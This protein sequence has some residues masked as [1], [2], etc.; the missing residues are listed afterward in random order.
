MTRRPLLIA[1][2]ISEIPFTIVK[3]ALALGH[4]PR[5]NALEPLSSVSKAL[6]LLLML[7]DAVAPMRLTDISRALGLNK[8]TALRLLVTLEKFGFVEKDLQRK[9]YRIGSNAFYVGSGYIAEGNSRKC[10]RS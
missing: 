5:I 10:F 7:R 6:K 1:V 9:Q 3:Q 4:S 2:L 8:V